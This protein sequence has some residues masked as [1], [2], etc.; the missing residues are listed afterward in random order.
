MHVLRG[1]TIVGEMA[2]VALNETAAACRVL[3]QT[4]PIGE[5]D[6]VVPVERDAKRAR[7]VARK[8]EG[9]AAAA[10]APQAPETPPAKPKTDGGGTAATPG[11]RQARASSEAPPATPRTDA[12]P[13]RGSPQIEKSA[14]RA[15]EHGADGRSERTH[16]PT[17]G[18]Q[19]TD[20]P[21]ARE[22]EDR[23][24]PPPGRSRDDWRTGFP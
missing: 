22:A 12:E 18:A 17:D 23:H 19:T 21:R 10:P 4:R 3:S 6:V 15:S 1:E 5:G 7:E 8:A 11:A 2:I 24:E 9:V 14:S 16:G 13:Y 20:S